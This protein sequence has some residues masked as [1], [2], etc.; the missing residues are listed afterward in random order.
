MC[1]RLLEINACQDQF[2]I[3]EIKKG[4]LD[5]AQ[6]AMIRITQEEQLGRQLFSGKYQGLT[7]FMSLFNPFPLKFIVLAVFLPKWW[8]SKLEDLW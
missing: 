6:Y 5:A 2:I 7:G 4:V 8:Q 1:C 3:S